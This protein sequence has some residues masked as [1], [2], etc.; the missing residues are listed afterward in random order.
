ME[1]F[2]CEQDA[3]QECARC[4]A[5]YCADHGEALCARCSDPA[6]ALPSYQVYRGSLLALIVG[7]VFALWLL[8]SPPGG[9]DL[10]AAT[11]APPNLG[12][13]VVLA[14]A[15]DAPATSTPAPTPSSGAPAS[16]PTA[17]P[18]AGE[19]D[20]PEPAATATSTPAPTAT[21]TQAAPVT[22]YTVESGDSLILIAEQLIE[23]GGDVDDFVLAI[24]E[25]NG[26]S[27]PSQIEIG[28]VLRIPAQ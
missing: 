21:P 23:P 15:T 28:E 11:Q 17:T 6:L 20:E 16:A 10:D 8:I 27:D 14:P 5:L 7:S 3:V 2:L 9:D 22:E 12:T 18:A 24:A 13:P 26:I 4:G 1:C 25:L 19:D